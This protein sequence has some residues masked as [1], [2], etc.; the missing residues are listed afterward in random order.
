MSAS[1]SRLPAAEGTGPAPAV[2]EG[3]SR[4]VFIGGATAVTGAVAAT[5]TLLGSG[6][7]QPVAAAATDHGATPRGPGSVSGAPRLPRGFADTFTSHYVQA[8][9]LRQHVVVGGDGP[10][11]LLLHGWPQTWYAWR[12]LMPALA[13]DFRL[14][15]P[16]QRGIG[17]SDKPATGYD[18]ATLA[19]DAV[20]LMDALGHQRFFVYG[21]DV[22]MPIAYAVAADHRDRVDR[23]VVSEAFLPGISQLPGLLI[24]DP[25]INARLWHLAFNQLP[26]EVNEAMVRGREDV[27]FGAEFDASAGSQKLPDHAVRYYVERL[28]ADRHALRGSFGFYREVWTTNDQ[29]LL[30]MDQR[31]TVPVL[32]IGGAESSMTGPGDVMGIVADHVQ[33]LVVP[34]GHWVAE[35]ATAEVHA[36]LSTF[37]AS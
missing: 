29:N 7:N 19:Q 33:T 34:H 3:L 18:A 22:G 15:V 16:D 31:L 10:P 2:G 1:S 32:A 13:Q 12:L 23:L 6:W 37:L 35:Q 20:S 25:L 30:R 5:G 24:R 36:A 21:T 11:L 4:R 28:R 14:V 17:L 8:N 26:A 9:G 27:Y